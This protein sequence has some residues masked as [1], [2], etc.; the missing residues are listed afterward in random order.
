MKKRS[1]KRNNKIGRINLVSI[2]MIF[3]IIILIAIVSKNVTAAK[4]Y[5][6]KKIVVHEYDTLWSI[7]TNIC[8]DNNDLSIYKVI[9]D[10][11]KLNNKENSLVYTNEILTIYVY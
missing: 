5:D 4:Y 1:R 9:K 6:T 7:A 8:E 2:I 11:K 10:I 3:L